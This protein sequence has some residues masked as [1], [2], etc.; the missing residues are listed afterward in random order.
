MDG[1]QFSSVWLMWWYLTSALNYGFSI[2]CTFCIAFNYFM[3]I[4]TPPGL[5]SDVFPIEAEPDKS[6]PAPKRGEGFSRYCKQCKRTKPPRAHHCHICDKCV[7]RM[8][9]H[10]PWVSNCVGHYN[11]KYFLLFLL[12]LWIGCLYVSVLS[13]GPFMLSNN[14]KVHWTGNASRGTVMFTF[15][16]T[17][18]VSLALSLMLMWHIYLVFSGQTTIE[19]YF[20]RYKAHE[21]SLRKQEYHNEFDLGFKKNFQTFFGLN[22]KHYWFMWLL[23]TLKMVQGDGTWYPT[24]SQHHRP[25]D[26]QG[27]HFV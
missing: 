22:E 4:F 11:H 10:C 26:K 2:Y 27:G 13:F 23:P 5:T 15:V 9:H 21:A 1:E 12:Y 14:Y 16:L 25:A 8:D 20:N 24:R 19:F 17:L 6:Q 7:M 18:S 3:T